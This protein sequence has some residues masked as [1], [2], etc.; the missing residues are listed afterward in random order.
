M[1]I[2]TPANGLRKF[3]YEDIEE[4]LSVCTDAEKNEIRTALN[5]S[6]ADG[7]QI[8]G[9]PSG[10]ASIVRDIQPNDWLLLLESDR[11][12]GQFYY[13]GQIIFRPQRELFKLS[14]LLW[15]EAKFPR[16]VFLKGMFTNFLWDEF[17]KEFNF[18][19]TWKLQGRT[20]RLL[21]E[22]ISNSR[23]VTELA[24]I[25]TVVGSLESD[26]QIPLDQVE[27]TISSLEGRRKLR[28]H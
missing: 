2:G 21:P 25:S 20:Y 9:I 6:A 3:H 28:Q 11:H 12:G 24:V 19:P 7:C 17:C 5:I 1:T 27:A 14:D 26:E 15:G 8:W 22:R 4:G 13:G 23:F 18:R 10:A 16:I